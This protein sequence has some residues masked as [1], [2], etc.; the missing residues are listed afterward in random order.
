M[1]LGL[2]VRIFFVWSL[3]GPCGALGCVGSLSCCSWCGGLRGPLIFLRAGC[4]GLLAVMLFPPQSPGLGP[5]GQY[6]GINGH[7][8]VAFCGITGISLQRG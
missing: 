3:C 8:R 7:G 5:V 1:C 6:L 4:T 2:L